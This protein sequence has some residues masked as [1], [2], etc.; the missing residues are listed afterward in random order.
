M[1][2][3]ALSRPEAFLVESWGKL[4]LNPLSSQ[5]AKPARSPPPWHLRC[6]EVHDRSFPISQ[7]CIPSLHEVRL[8]LRILVCVCVY[9]RLC[10]HINIMSHFNRLMV[11]RPPGRG[12]IIRHSLHRYLSTLLGYHVQYS[13]VLFQSY[14]SQPNTLTQE[15]THTARSPMSS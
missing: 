2:A 9:I 6:K 8:R 7:L 12:L 1:W 5:P 15:S 4:F 13:Q 3:L 11:A 10:I 14:S